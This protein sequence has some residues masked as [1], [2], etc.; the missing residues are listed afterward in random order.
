MTF[1]QEKRQ[2]LAWMALL[3]PL[4]L[5]FN[6]ALEWPAL[7]V[8]AVFLV[9]FLQRV[10][11]R[12]S[13]VLPNW[14]LN[15]LGLAYLPVLAIDLQASFARSRPVTALLHLI[16]FLILVKIFS[17]R[18][19]KDKWHLVMACF[20]LFLGG[21]A[22][23]THL[24]SGFYLLGFMMF[25]LAL[26]ARF[27][28]L[29]MLAGVQRPRQEPAAD[30]GTPSR[31][32]RPIPFRGPLVA[33]T[34]LIV[35]IAVPTFATLPRLREPFIL[36]AGGSGGLIRTSG[37][38]DSVDL[39]LTSSIRNNREVVLRVKYSGDDA[40][41]DADLRFKGATYDR[42][43]GRRWHR[44]LQH[45]DT[46][47]PELDPEHGQLFRVSA[48][49]AVAK[50]EIFRERLN[51]RSLLLPME[52]VGVAIDSPFVHVDLGSAVYLPGP[53]ADTIRYDVLVASQP[54]IEA[55]LARLAEASLEVA[56]ANPLS[57]LDQ[58]GVS[59]AIRQLAREV[60]GEG[61]PAE[62]ADR[63]EAHLLAQY[64]YTLDFLGRD[65]ENP[66]EDF[67]FTYKSGHCEYF[68]SSMVLLLRAVGIPARL[69]TGFLGAEYNRLEG[70]YMVRQENAH[71]WVEAYTP[72]RGWQVFDPTPP[73]GRPG[74]P[75]RSLLQLMSQ[76][77]DYLTFRWDRWV[78]T[79]GADDQRTFFQE[80]RER[81]TRLWQ[82]L[83]GW[84]SQEEDAAPSL[85]VGGVESSKD[86]VIREPKLWLDK[87]PLPLAVL[88]F[89]AVVAGIVVWHRRRPLSGAAAYK[90][91]RSWLERAGVTV[92]DSLAPLE[93]EQLALARY[94]SAAAPTRGLLEL[95]L[96]ESF[97]EAP[98]DAS[99]RTRL[100][101]YLH[102]VREAMKQDDRQLRSGK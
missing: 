54:R 100:R 41:N 6:E 63:I 45:A 99:E 75:E 92:T 29:H 64:V 67:L 82:E 38:S 77:Y 28:H 8:Y 47:A 31:V 98:L 4:P 97:G 79:Y 91:L 89:L 46:L 81:F 76:F 88:G 18:R 24:A 59:E 95:Y 50:V 19:E 5:P 96:R 78:L 68:A 2:M 15:V 90:L 101:E 72:S 73:E 25:T 27:A 42:Y 30:P 55:R 93:L 52:T 83:T 3:A 21:M 26:L 53:P 87:V 44:R 69:S 70:Y 32:R 61:T 12:R 65:S 58:S 11:S 22:T 84:G 40:A 7:F 35:A 39:S 94:P 37:F 80:M 10:E 1:G 56:A 48:A 43:E 20:F 71:A 49:K 85:P 51:S 57:A 23:S 34:L 9:W 66:I 74:A 36:G 62:K 16:M 102:G 13:T 17:I 60:A 33:G 86:D 14:V